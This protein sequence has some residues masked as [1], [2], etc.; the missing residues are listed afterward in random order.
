MAINFDATGGGSYNAGTSYT[1]SH[2][3]SGDNR[4]LFV[5]VMGGTSDTITG[6]SYNSN[7][8]TLIDKQQVG[9]YWSYL[10]YL[11]APSTGANNVVISSS[12]SIN[13]FGSSASYTG[14]KQTSTIEDFDKSGATSA[15]SISITSASTTNGAWMISQISPSSNPGNLSAGSGTTARV[16]G[17]ALNYAGIVDSNSGFLGNYTLNISSGSSQ[18]LQMISAVFSPATAPVS[19]IP[20]I[21]N[22]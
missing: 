7:S 12:S 21:I 10:F 18:N 22:C 9:T 3:C 6:V 11:I 2:T 16:L 1:F 4:I 20:K 14:V 5:S 15:T 13:I 17:G 19:F 8:L